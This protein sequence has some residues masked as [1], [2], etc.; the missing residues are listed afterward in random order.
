[1]TQIQLTRVNAGNPEGLLSA[2]PF[3]VG[4]GILVQG[5]WR[6]SHT[7]FQTPTSDF[8]ASSQVRT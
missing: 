5:A 1:M 3:V 6:F 2:E 7:E 8:A 4:T